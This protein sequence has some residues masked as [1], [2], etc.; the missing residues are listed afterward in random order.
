MLS[1]NVIRIWNDRIEEY[2][3]HAVRR[4]TTKAIN[5]AQVAQVATS[6]GIRWTVLRVESTGGHQIT[7]EGLNKE[8]GAELKQMLDSKVHAAKVGPNFMQ[9]VA[10]TAQPTDVADQ[11]MKLAELRDRG[12][13]SDDEFTAQKAKLLG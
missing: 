1:P 11:L 6:R 2:E 10:P 3:H 4:K 9:P 8:R 12:V 5:Y 13:L 7:I